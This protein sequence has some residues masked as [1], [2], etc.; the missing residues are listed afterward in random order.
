MLGFLRRLI[1]ASSGAV[2]V[3]E[4]IDT[5]AILALI[6]ICSAQ[7]MGV[8]SLKCSQYTD[9]EHTSGIDD[10]DRRVVGLMGDRSKRLVGRIAIV[11]GGGRGIRHTVLPMTARRCW[12][13]GSL[14]RTGFDARLVTG[15]QPPTGL[16]L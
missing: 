2:L 10:D 14:N 9:L 8:P 13:G 5:E 12:A 16:Y 1:N 4:D 7:P 15:V 11:T 3:F 6:G